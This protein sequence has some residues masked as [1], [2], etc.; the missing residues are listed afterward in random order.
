MAKIEI[1]DQ[2]WE[3]FKAFSDR[4]EIADTELFLAQWLRARLKSERE[5]DGRYMPVVNAVVIDGEGRILIVGNRY[6]RQSKL[7]WGLPGGGVEPGED[8]ISTLK[9]ELHEETGL[10]AASVGRLLWVSQVYPGPQATGILAFVFE[11]KEW[12]GSLSTDNEETGGVVRQVRFTKVEEA[13]KTLHPNFGLPLQDWMSNP[14]DGVRLHW[15][16]ENGS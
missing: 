14:D 1:E 8:L 3:A 13:R 4:L 5:S 9:R 6:D 2:V 7:V 12:Q 15:K 11:I 16:E 10:Q